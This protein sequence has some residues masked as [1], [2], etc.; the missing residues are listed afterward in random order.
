MT[1]N[2]GTIRVLRHESNALSGNPLGDPHVRDLYVYLPP[3]YKSE[4]AKRYPVIYCLTGFTGRGKMFLNDSA[5]SL[6]LAERIDRL[7]SEGAVRPFIAVMPD[8]FTRYGGSQYINSSATGN[9]EDYLTEEL[10]PFVDENLRTIPDRLARGVAGKSSGGYGSLI[11]AMRHADIFC[12]AASI[13]GDC[14]F[15]ICYKPDLRKAFRAVGGE[16]LKLVEKFWNEEAP[17]AKSDFDGLNI[18]GMASCYS[19]NEE[20]EWGFDLPFDVVTGEVLED[21]WERWLEH[22]PVHLAEKHLDSLRSLELLFIDAGTIDE[23]GLDIGARVLSKK[24]TELGVPH[25]TEE[26]EGGHFNI[27]FRYNRAFEEISEVLGYE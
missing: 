1:E 25:S 11:M 6:N 13:A 4:G 9:Y 15:E 5:F 17:K 2:K 24:L 21:V 19:P 18:I 16:P 12:A 3:G 20:S 7:V 27:N 14:Y 10:V 8:C 23:F 22:D 26:F